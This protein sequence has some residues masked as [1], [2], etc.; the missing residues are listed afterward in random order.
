MHAGAGSFP[1][2][3]RSLLLKDTVGMQVQA[4]SDIS[5]SRSPS[6]SNPRKKEERDKYYSWILFKLFRQAPP[7]AQNSSCG[8]KFSFSHSDRQMTPSKPHA[9]ALR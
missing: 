2:F 9:L 3:Q 5:P 6:S 4:G 7:F 8:T 1:H